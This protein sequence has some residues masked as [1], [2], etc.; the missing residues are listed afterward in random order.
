MWRR[1]HVLALG[2]GLAALAAPRL[3]SA[4][5]VVV[6]EMRGTARGERVWFAP[7]GIAVPAGTLLRFTNRDPG[8]SHTTTAYHPDIFDRP[9]RIPRGAKPWDSGLLL[10]DQSFEIA[11][12]RPGVY[13]FYCVPH[14]MAGMV[15]RIVVGKPGDA[16]WQDASREAGDLP[17]AARG[18][19]P[20]VADIL[21]SGRIDRGAA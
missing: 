16:G 8:N 7:Q 6:I 19:F 20:P 10:P 9:R 18:A 11:L 5:A 14:E 4:A 3:T 1:R 17:A 15:G 2:G 21:V 13:D 12:D